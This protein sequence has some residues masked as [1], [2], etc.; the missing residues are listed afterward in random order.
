[1]LAGLSKV[2]AKYIE[3]KYK[4]LEEGLLNTENITNNWPL[5]CQE[6]IEH[7]L[8][9]LNFL[10]HGTSAHFLNRD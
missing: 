1:L 3:L 7:T 4:E 6:D 8:L 9:T 2:V 5:C 10:I